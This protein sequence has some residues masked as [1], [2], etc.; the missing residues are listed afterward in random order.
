MVHV[1][2]IQTDAVGAEDVAVGVTVVDVI[3]ILPAAGA[4]L[5]AEDQGEQMTL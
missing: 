5:S 1:G 3:G 2:G 4:I